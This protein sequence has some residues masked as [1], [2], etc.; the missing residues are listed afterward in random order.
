LILFSFLKYSF[1]LIAA[2]LLVLATCLCLKMRSFQH[3]ALSGK[4]VVVAQQKDTPS[5]ARAN[6]E[7]WSSVV[8]FTAPSGDTFRFVDKL[9]SHPP[10]H[11]IGDSVDVLWLPRDPHGARLDDFP[12]LWLNSLVCA[13]LGGV[14]LGFAATAFFGQRFLAKKSIPDLTTLL[15]KRS[16]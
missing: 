9:S 16:P 8:R 2:L 10:R 13:I 6:V 5:S 7:H 11:R 1:G 12:S 14:F 15:R 4:G 3:K